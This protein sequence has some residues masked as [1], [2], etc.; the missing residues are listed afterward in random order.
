MP[1]PAM[2]ATKPPVL[3]KPSRDFLSKKQLFEPKGAV[4]VQVPPAPPTAPAAEKQGTLHFFQT[5]L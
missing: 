3:P 5:L 4:P 2:A 1:M